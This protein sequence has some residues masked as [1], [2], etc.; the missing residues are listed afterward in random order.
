MSALDTLHRN[1]DRNQG[2]FDRFETQLLELI[3]RSGESGLL[4]GGIRELRD[5]ASLK[6]GNDEARCVAVHQCERLLWWLAKPAWQVDEACALVY[7]IDP[8]AV[9]DGA[10]PA[11]CHSLDGR[12]LTGDSSEAYHAWLLLESL[13]LH[14]ESRIEQATTLS[15][16]S[17]EISPAEFINWCQGEGVDTSYLRLIRTLVG[18]GENR[19]VGRLPL[20][21]VQ[22]FTSGRQ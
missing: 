21:D 19:V 4:P 18:I 9:K 16:L 22:I 17:C 12:L 14:M 7:G 11:G 20:T 10:V 6:A 1:R 13:Y 5:V 3:R 8:A 2:E 15:D